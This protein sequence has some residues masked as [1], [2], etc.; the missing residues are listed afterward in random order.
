MQ[1][2][3]I[4][5]L[6]GND[7]INTVLHTQ[8]K[9]T[10]PQNTYLAPILKELI[11]RK[12]E[13]S[14]RHN[15]KEFQRS[16]SSELS[17]V[18][19]I[20]H[21]VLDSSGQ[22]LD[23]AIRA[24]MEPRLGHD[25]SKVRIHN[26]AKAVESARAVNA[27]AYTVGQDVVFGAGRYTPRMTAGR[28]LLAHELTH[29]VQ[30]AQGITRL[31][32]HYENQANKAADLV[33]GGESA[34]Q[35]SAGLTSNALLL[36]RQSVVSSPHDQMVV[37]RARRR[38]TLLERYADEWTARE[39]RRIRTTRESTPLLESRSQMDREGFDI[40]EAIDPGGRIRLETGNL[41]VLN[42]RP[43]N[44]QITEEELRIGIRF[45]IRFE[46][47]QLANRLTDLRAGLQSGIEMV[48][49]QELRG[50]VFGGRR[51]VI[52]PLLTPVPVDAGRDLDYWLINVRSTD[53]APAVYPGCSLDE[54]PEGVP[55]SVTDSNCAGGVMNIPPAHITQ[56]HVLGHELL[57]LFGLVDRYAL[58][59]SIRASGE[60]SHRLDPSRATGG[61]LDPLGAESGQILPEDLAFLFD[62]LGIY[63]MEENRGL[64]TLQQLER[65]GMTIETVRA[66]IHRLQDIIRLGRDPHS[67]LPIRRDF[68]DLMVRDVENL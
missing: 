39:G 68:N 12:Y 3:C 50:E 45:H 59:E 52:E 48:W 23:P 17:N 49:N 67:L 4:G 65:R 41:A 47:P 26:D 64:D 27:L 35:K 61:R 54:V 42:R 24:Y 21:E 34:L 66:E 37:E 22:P 38:L 43:L 33:V 40:G 51:L 15:K 10:S 28:H 32:N 1:K 19:P 16:N 14:D 8:V 29:V 55:T 20:V 36:Q 25:F 5:S 62:H 56:G 60:R 44:I 9:Y 31:K 13:D 30:Q 53:V 63:A 7:R 46:D 11:Q 57:H 58:V 18:P 6:W 2:A